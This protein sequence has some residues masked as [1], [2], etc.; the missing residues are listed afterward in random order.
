MIGIGNIRMGVSLEETS[1]DD[2]RFSGVV[3]MKSVGVGRAV[4]TYWR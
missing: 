2:V 4:S 1:C 3:F